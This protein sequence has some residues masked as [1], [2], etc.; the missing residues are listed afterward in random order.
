M[1]MLVVDRIAARRHT[2]TDPG[3]VR[4]ALPDSSTVNRGSLAMATVDP[5]DFPSCKKQKKRPMLEQPWILWCRTRDSRMAGRTLHGHVAPR[6]HRAAG[7]SA[8]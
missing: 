1:M 2:A 8:S 3:H 7:Q 5:W 6:D 4:Q